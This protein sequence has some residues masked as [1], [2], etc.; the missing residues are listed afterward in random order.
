MK[1][2]ILIF[3]FAKE[4]KKNIGNVF[5]RLQKNCKNYIFHILFCFSELTKLRQLFK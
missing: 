4:K 1:G 3:V 5:V 2:D